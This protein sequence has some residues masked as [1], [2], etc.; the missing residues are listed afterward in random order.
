MENESTPL[1]SPTQHE[2]D[3]IAPTHPFS[4]YV[5]N[6]HTGKYSETAI[7]FPADPA[8][9]RSFLDGVGIVDWRDIKGIE[10]SANVDDPTK[11]ESDIWR[12]TNKLNDMLYGSETSPHTLNELNHLAARIEGL[13]ARGEDGGINILLANI[14]TDKNSD[15]IADMINL[16]FDENIN[17][18]DCWPVYDAKSY[19]DLL[20][21]HFRQDEHYE[22]YNHLAESSGPEG[23]AFAA[24]VEMLEKHTDYKAF[25][26]AV[27]KEEGGVFTEQGYLVG[28]DEGLLEIYRSPEDIPQEHII[29]HE[30]P[31]ELRF[32]TK[33]IPHDADRA[34]LE[35]LAAKIQG[36][37]AEQ[38]KVFGAVVEAGMYCG[39][40][41]EIINTTENLDCFNLRPISGEDE[42][43]MRRVEQD[44]DDGMKA[45]D[46]LSA[47]DDPNDRALVKHIMILSRAVDDGMYGHH[48]AKEEGGI[49]TNQGLLTVEATPHIIY[50]GTQD[51]PAEYRSSQPI[52]DVPDERTIGRAATDKSSPDAKPS[53]LAQIAE[54]REAQRR[55]PKESQSRDALIADRKKSDPE[56]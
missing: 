21:N 51:L 54:H 4:V 55:E 2:D 35:Y 27:A 8:E 49:F 9:L 34:E 47:S 10:V 31:D 20:V 18:F 13:A 28:G 1:V 30:Y 7:P 19:G 44:A 38:M 32:L 52:V 14:E 45:F 46:R 3:D 40:V 22:V 50:L 41:A 23:K 29:Q 42:Y 56:L 48:A 37:D 53:V 36:M 5:Q 15:T 6:V 16:T 26:N 12:L 24:H 11:D 39:S 43:G 25:G 17:K 33:H